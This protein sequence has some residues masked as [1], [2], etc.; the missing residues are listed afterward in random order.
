MP[1]AEEAAGGESALP[2]SL[3]NPRPHPPLAGS[4]SGAGGGGPERRPSFR[5]PTRAREGSRALSPP[6]APSLGHLGTPTPSPPSLTPQDPR[7][8]GGGGRALRRQV[9]SA[10]P[11]PRIRTMGSRTH[12]VPVPQ[13]LSGTEWEPE[14]AAPSSTGGGGGPRGRVSP[15]HLQSQKAAPARSPEGSEPGAR[16]RRS[17]PRGRRGRSWRLLGPLPPSPH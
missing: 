3:P 14:A 9:L 5:D 1:A 16:R 8:T 7:V 12:P 15:P 11:F 13:T 17:R 4:G 6:L 2:S 10:V